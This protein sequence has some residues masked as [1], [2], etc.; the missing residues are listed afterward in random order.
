MNRAT[1][2]LTVVIPVYNEQARLPATL[3]ALRD[4]LGACPV[5]WELI[6]VDDGS[7]DGTRRLV[8][9]AARRDPRIRLLG[10]PDNRGKG[11]A[12]R[13]GVLSSAGRLVLLSDADLATPIA[14]LAR[15]LGAL[16]PGYGAAIGSRPRGRRHPLRELP[17]RLGGALIRLL[18]APGITDTQCGF[19]LFDGAKARAAFL[20]AVIDGWAF[21]VEILCLFAKAG[22]PVAEVPVEWSHRPGSKFRPLDYLRIVAEIVRIR[23]SHG[24]P[25]PAVTAPVPLRAAA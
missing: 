24:R 11:H 18:V 22:W 25:R 8:G 23:R 15:L 12:V 19:K 7:T 17:A 3:A 9:A 4:H 1:V 13:T 2:D 21:D 14:E 10:T 5:S 6:V 16:R 20:D